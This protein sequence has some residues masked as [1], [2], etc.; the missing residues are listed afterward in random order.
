MNRSTRGEEGDEKFDGRMPE[1]ERWGVVLKATRQHWNPNMAL[2]MWRGHPFYGGTLV[3]GLFKSYDKPKL[4]CK[5]W[6]TRVWTLTVRMKLW[7]SVWRMQMKTR[8]VLL[9]GK[10]SVLII[11]TFG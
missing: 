11:I 6:M 7:F 9:L 3:I 5:N 4:C 10:T 2:A 1:G 8:L